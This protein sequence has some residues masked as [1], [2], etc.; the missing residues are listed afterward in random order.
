[1]DYAIVLYMNDE[2]TAIPIFSILFIVT[3]FVCGKSHS[4]CLQL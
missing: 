2:K 4:F 3:S 1:M